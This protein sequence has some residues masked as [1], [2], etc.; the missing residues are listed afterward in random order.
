MLLLAACQTGPGPELA[1]E[2]A[3][4]EIPREEAPEIFIAF[5][6]P[7]PE[8]A[9][10]EIPFDPGSIPPEVIAVTMHDIQGMIEDLNRIIRSR[11]Y[12]GWLSYLS[13]E[14]IAAHSAPDYLKQISETSPRLTT[15]NVVL[16]NLRDYF[17]YVV[18]PSRANDRVDD[19]EYSAAN[20]VK[21][22]TV[23]ARGQRLRLYDLEQVDGGWKIV[24]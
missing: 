3:S 13:Q 6:P 21:A 7:P 2:P 1:A 5:E 9:A 16:N 12:D 22:Y 17:V 14:F 19:I 23:S 24:N 18:V 11:N 15:Q 8:P 4:V 10:E 20:R